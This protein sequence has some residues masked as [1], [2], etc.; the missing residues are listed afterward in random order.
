MT[1]EERQRAKDAKATLK[2]FL[3]LFNEYSGEV[4]G[5]HRTIL[6]D[7][8]RAQLQRQEPQVTAIILEIIGDGQISVGNIGVITYRDILVT[9]LMGGNNEDPVRAGRVHTRPNRAP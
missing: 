6:L 7:E 9:A 5:H 8:L 1:L 3:K 2:S 4:F